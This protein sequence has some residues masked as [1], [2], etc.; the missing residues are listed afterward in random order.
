MISVN[1][2]SVSCEYGDNGIPFTLFSLLYQITCGCAV[3]LP[4]LECLA[5]VL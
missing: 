4:H 5:V 2:D 3:C 1:V